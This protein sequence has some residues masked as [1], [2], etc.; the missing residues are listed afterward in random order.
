MELYQGLCASCHGRDGKGDLGPSLNNTSFLRV[1]S[2]G[3]LQAIIVRG[4]RGTPMTPFGIGSSGIAQL[5]EEEI[6]NIIY[7][8]RNWEDE[9]PAGS[10]VAARS[11]SAK[12]AE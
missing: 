3:F 1:V 4:R 5:S 9:A 7:F 10:K 6:N 12:H 8:I 11:S 2:D